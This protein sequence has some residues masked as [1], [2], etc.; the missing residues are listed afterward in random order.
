MESAKLNVLVG[1]VERLLRRDATR[2]LEKIVR[3]THPADLAALLE[4][5]EPIDRPRLIE[6]LGDDA[7][8]AEVLA[9]LDH[10][11]AGSL[12]A[13]YPVER[14]AQLLTRV[15]PDDRADLLGA[16]PAE[17]AQSLIDKMSGEKAEEVEGLLSYGESTA[18]G[19]MSPNAF[20]LQRETVVSEAIAALQR[21]ER[22]E[23]AFYVYVV[24][25]FGHLVGVISLRQLVSARPDKRLD[26]IMTS[27]VITVRPEVDQEEV[28][29]IASRYSF[30]AVP[31]VDESNK[32]LGIV[33][34][35][36][37]IDVLGEEATEDILKLQGAGQELT[38]AE[39][40]FRGLRIRFPWLL[41]TA[42][43]G[44]LS[45]LV[46]AAFPTVTGMLEVAAFIPVVMAMAGS[47]GTQ[48]ATIVVRGLQTG[49]LARGALA[50][51]VGRQIAV[52]GL[53]GAIY[54]VLIAGFGIA[55]FHSHA[56][57]PVRFAAV[58][59]GAVASSTALASLLGASFPVVCARLGVDPAVA[60]APLVTTTVDLAA[61]AVYFAAARWLL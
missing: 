27:D 21:A 4:G 5:L 36:D 49:R 29:R 60:T 15:D 61:I 44:C 10:Q 11:L 25:E 47:V 35:D 1:T 17:L 12:L 40:A 14:A 26:E 20:A 53:L 33:T 48:S 13:A 18:G 41:A 42:L 22:V 43:G 58:L 16:L 56:D 50:G 8:R 57:R 2:A 31:V 46:I 59:G 6:A 52:G 19:S 7:R 51:A 24:N 45:A 28:A 38:T 23:M 39:S 30:L 3:R 9:H 34:I 37:V 32:L 54:G 55:R